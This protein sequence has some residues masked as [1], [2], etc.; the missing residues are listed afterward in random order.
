M[1]RKGA[2]TSIGIPL[3]SSKSTLDAHFFQVV[4]T[5]WNDKVKIPSLCVF[6]Y[7]L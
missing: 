2:N 1:Y 4:N 5:K 3:K 7:E 6:V